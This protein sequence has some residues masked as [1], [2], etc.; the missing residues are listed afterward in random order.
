MKL[1]E[2][3][4]MNNEDYKLN[5]T[6][7]Q[8]EWKERHQNKGLNKFIYDGIV[9]ENLW[10]KAEKRITLFLKEAYLKEDV[11]EGNLC[12]SLNKW[13]VWKMWRTVSDWIYALQN[14]TVKSIPAYHSF[15]F[16][17]NDTSSERVRSISVVNIKKS[18]GKSSSDHDDLMN[19]VKVDS[20]LIQRQISEINPEIIVCGNT[21]YY[22][23]IVYGAELDKKD[24]IISNA[25]YNGIEINHKDF[26]EKGYIWAGDT[27]IINYCHPA[28]H[29]HRQGKYYAF[30]A[31]YQQALIE[32]NKN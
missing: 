29:F 20:D 5:C 17:D 31:L 7:V 6:A 28:N 4:C 24:N 10:E 2:M 23:E 16:N 3:T 9:N 21:G 12:R 18:E 25:K 1:K 27:L 13:T 8:H 11:S 14:V 32:K 26:N 15:N 19:F 22:F 30:A